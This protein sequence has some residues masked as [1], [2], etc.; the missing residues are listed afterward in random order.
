MSNK[1]NLSEHFEKLGIQVNEKA[2]IACCKLSMPMHAMFNG[3][4][5]SLDLPKMNEDETHL[6][7]PFRALSAVLIEER[8]VDFSQEGVLKS[9]ARFLQ[10]QTIYTNHKHD[11]NDWVG[12]VAKSQFND[13]SEPQGIDTMLKV[14]KKWNERLIDGLK[15]EPP[16]VHSVSVDVYFDYRRSHPDLDDFWW[17]LGEDIDGEKVRIIATKIKSF[18]EIS[19]VWQGADVTAKRIGLEKPEGAQGAGIEL[20]S[21][22]PTGSQGDA[23]VKIARVLL[24]KLGLRPSAYGFKGNETEAEFDASEVQRMM[25]DM[26]GI[27]LENSTVREAL[28]KAG[29]DLSEDLSEKLMKMAENAKDGEAYL[30]DMRS[31]AIKFARL[32]N[33][34]EISQVTEKAITNASL[35]DA[36]DFR[37]EYAKAAED[38]F[39]VV[40]SE[41]GAKLSR[42][43]GVHSE[44]ESTSINEADYEL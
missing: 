44:S 17:L 19:F 36:K 4:M 43:G 7:A 29:I 21:Q 13:K 22:E 11:V 8:W 15:E 9:G 2:G 23:N 14:N 42:S 26:A 25:S 34:G 16:A 1:R 39:P 10:G 5:V 41:C 24:E 20:H 35:E 6:F 37:D 3:Q 38:K 18:G 27:A 40:C 33:G 28:T 31:E 32:S 12:V 30:S